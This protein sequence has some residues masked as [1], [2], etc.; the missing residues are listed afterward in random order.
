MAQNEQHARSIR[1]PAVRAAKEAGQRFGKVTERP[2]TVTAREA[3]K[4]TTAE[5]R[6]YLAERGVSIGGRSAA[7]AE[8]DEG[9]E[10]EAAPAAPAKAAAKSG[11]RKG[12]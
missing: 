12:R 2:R 10:E 8:E 5:Q 6:K 11:A 1:L 9:E 4:L 3:A 7:A